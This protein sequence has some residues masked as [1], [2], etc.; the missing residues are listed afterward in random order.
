MIGLPLTTTELAREIR[1]RAISACEAVGEYL[2]RI[3]ASHAKV[4]AVVTLDAERA[5]AR[6]ALADEAL[7]RGEAWGPLHGVPFTL[8]DGHETAGVRTSVGLPAFA[9][10]V[11]E[12]DGAVAARLKAAGGILI[13]K[14][15]VPPMLMSAQTQNPLF[16]RT[17]NP[18]NLERTVGGSSGGAGA[19]VALALTAFDVGSD[20][21]GS[22]RIPAGYCGIFGLKPTANRIPLTGHIP[23]PPGAPRIERMM[24]TAGP[25]TRSAEDLALIASVLV[26]PDGRDVEV[27]PVPWVPAIRPEVR[28][29][30]VAFASSFPGVPTSAEVRARVERVASELASAGARVEERGPGFALEAL[31]AAWG[32]NMRILGAVMSELFGATLPIPAPEGA[33]V[34]ATSLVKMQADRDAL[35]V[36]LECLFDDFDVLLLPSTISTAFPHGPPR[37]PIPVDGELVE[38]RFVDHYLYPFNFTGHPALAVPAGLAADGL[39]LGIQL[40]S[41]RFSDERLIAIA[42]VVAEIAGG[43]AAPPGW[44]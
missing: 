44:W 20:M 36:S 1:G 32:D 14:T 29:L 18:W 19:A 15:N 31:R 22:I 35:M 24:A 34:T 23:P 26:G 21:S 12:Q 5:L 39:P 27:A 17:N 2:R 6:A 7:A 4:N 37:T 28:D 33:P 40:V 13:G 30:R 38:S 11:P 9:D 41:K 43:Y 42:G 8:K 3:E 25:M 10:H 16:G